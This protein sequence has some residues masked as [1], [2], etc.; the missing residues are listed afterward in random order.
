[1][2]IYSKL[3]NIDFH[4]VQDEATENGIVI[5]VD[6]GKDWTSFDVVAKLRS[7]TKIKKIGHAG[8]LDPL[9]TGLLIVCVGRK[10][11]KQIS[12]FQ[13]AG[14][15]YTAMVKLG[16][17]TK[18]YDSEFDEENLCSTEHVTREMVEEILPKFIG[19][20]EQLP[21]A[22]S[23]RK[24]KGRR[25]YEMA[26][27]NIEM[28]IAPAIVE[29]Q[30]ITI[31]KIDLPYIELDVR[32]SKGTYIRS[33]AFDIG[34]EL[35]VG[36]YLSD[37]RRTEIGEYSVD[38]AITIQEISDLHDVVKEHDYKKVKIDMNK[39]FSFDEI[40]HDPNSVITVGTFDGIH[41]GHQM[42]LSR[43]SEVAAKD[44]LR[45]VLLTLHPHPQIVLQKAE[46]P[47]VFLLSTIEER[48]RLFEKYELENVLV[49]PFTKEF[50]GTD[51]EVFVVN[52]LLEKVGFKKILIGF[53]HLFGNNRAGDIELLHR[54]SK[55]YG[56]EIEQ[57]GEIQESNEKI[58]STKIRRALHEG[59]LEEANKM[60]GYEYFV[61][62]RVVEGEKRGRTIG[63]PTAN[64]E[65][66]SK[67]KLM[68]SNGVYFV[69][70]EIEGKLY[71]GMA[72]KGVRPTFKNDAEPNLEV[73]FFDFDK[74]IYGQDIPIYFHKFIREEKKFA[75]IDEIV[76]QLNKDKENCIKMIK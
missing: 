37:L 22:F 21:P 7:L 39:Y 23:A 34:K 66:P 58:S 36:G 16:A 18:S 53:D 45:P 33:L 41:L 4:T 27:K 11:T 12:T 76:A 26:R 54:L 73:H 40:D 70:S 48:M 74:D 61:L 25:M 24:I 17:T 55:E 28:E 43:L 14:K 30:S 46:K 65:S 69:S 42:I 49:I 19:Q 63:F 47:P 13:D 51:P 10:A 1:M 6:K 72:N 68:P 60:F 2:T 31:E 67:N 75:G 64:I 32:C 57:L 5:L 8:T 3:E 38:N 44:K 15:R 56:F 52:Y 62:G 35:G 9:A 71:Y 20:I 59:N 29:I 50:A